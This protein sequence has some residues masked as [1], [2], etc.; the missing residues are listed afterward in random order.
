M[1]GQ[2]LV[3]AT[4]L[5]TLNNPMAPETAA[6]SKTTPVDTKSIEQEV[7]DISGYYTCKGVET[8]GKTYTGVAVIA[9]KNDVYVIQWMIGAGSTFSGLAI[10]QGN[11][12]AASWAVPGER[13]LMRGINLYTIQPGPRLVGRWATLPGPGVHQ[14]ETLTFL[15]KLD[16]EE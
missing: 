9:K 14:S 12:F 7:G 4:A 6:R 1:F 2:L 8:G 15:K 10:R 11:T 13:G 3:V 5:A 16:V